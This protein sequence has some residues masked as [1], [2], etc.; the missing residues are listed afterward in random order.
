MI[1][2]GCHI[3]LL[4]CKGGLTPIHICGPNSSVLSIHAL[5]SPASLLCLPVVGCMSIVTHLFVFTSSSVFCLNDSHYHKCSTLQTYWVYSLFFGAS[6]FL[7]A[8]V[9]AGDW[10]LGAWGRNTYAAIDVSCT[11]CVP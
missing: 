8:V 10:L 2:C 3:L 5:L 6:C 11:V 4:V 7:Y 9:M 1:D